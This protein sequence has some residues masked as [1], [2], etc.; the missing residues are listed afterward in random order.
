MAEADTLQTRKAHPTQDVDSATAVPAVESHSGTDQYPNP[1][2]QQQHHIE[3][4]YGR[5]HHQQQQ[6]YNVMI[7][8]V[9]HWPAIFLDG[10]KTSAHFAVLGFQKVRSKYQEYQGLHSGSYQVLPTT[11]LDTRSY[12][13]QTSTRQTFSFG[14]KRQQKG[15]YQA[16]CSGR[17]VTRL[18]FFL[19]MVVTTILLLVIPH[20]LNPLED[21]S[22]WI[23][24]YNHEEAVKITVPFG[25][26]LHVSDIKK[27]ALNELQNGYS[28]FA[29]GN[30]KLISKYNGA[31]SP[32]QVWDNGRD[33]FR[34]SANHP[35]LVIDT[36]YE[37]FRFLDSALGC[38]ATPNEYSQQRRD[39]YNVSFDPGYRGY[40]DLARIIDKIANNEVRFDEWEIF[41]LR[42]A[43]N[44]PKRN[45][46]RTGNVWMKGNFN[47]NMYITP[48]VPYISH[49]NIS[50]E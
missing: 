34:S 29:P 30:V 41:Y 38:F 12:P 44:D 5:S 11:N 19:V 26:K 40:A 49:G 50:P 18:F 45:E 42:D 15:G 21:R 23:R 47:R 24:Y 33:T 4:G 39:P 8:T 32:D 3:H 28:K 1:F 36:K 7:P 25:L 13:Q 14:I 9:D 37:L 17:R 43:F 48:D 27:R 35:I 22:I 20:R 6:H 31:L 46:P 16:T 10:L 2:Q